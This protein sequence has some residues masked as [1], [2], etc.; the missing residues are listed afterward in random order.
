M[1]PQN[2]TS[3]PGCPSATATAMVSLCT[4]SP[5][6]ARVWLMIRHPGEMLGE[7]PRHLNHAGP[8]SIATRDPA[9]GHTIW[10][11]AGSEEGGRTAAILFS[12]TTTCRSLG[13]DSFAYLRDVLDRVG[14]HPARRVEE[15]LPDRWKGLRSDADP[16]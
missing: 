9:G 3:P 5:T 13:I 11:F 2:R 15:L 1:V 14:T 10:T 7:R 6:K 16:R 12:M 8:Q 4:S